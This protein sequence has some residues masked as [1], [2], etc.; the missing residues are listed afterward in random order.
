[1]P[2]NNLLINE[3]P[4]Q[5]LPSLAGKIGL[6]E[7]IILQ[8]LHYW[9]ENPKV[10]KVIDGIKW[11]YNTYGAWKENFPFWSEHTIQRA[12]KNLEQ[13]NLVISEQKERE[14]YDR[15]KYYRIN[16]AELESLNVPFWNNRT[17]QNGTFEQ[18]K[19]ERS[20]NES[21]TNTE[22]TTENTQEK[23]DFSSFQIGRDENGKPEV[24][25]K[26]IIQHKPTDEL[27]SDNTYL[28]VTSFLPPWKG[29]DLKKAR[30]TIKF[31]ADRLD[32]KD[33][34][35]VA[36]YLRP[37]YLEWINRTGK[38]GYKYPKTGIGWLIEWA[39]VGEIP[40]A[41]KNGIDLCLR[42]E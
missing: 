18:A 25:I 19:M 15:Q 9:L 21:E 12:I 30:E 31:I 7:A 14:S 4:L 16:Y 41:N 1:M 29:D 40:P 20:L 23:N 36:E 28:Q 33:K 17:S 22:T 27:F 35:K 8:Q 2:K 24:Q 10:G 42:N 26:E 39:M 6:N 5:V 3:P 11:V 32:T 34:S 38:S 37:F 13:L